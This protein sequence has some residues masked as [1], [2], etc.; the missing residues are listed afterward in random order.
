MIIK[1]IK[2]T[3]L[4]CYGN[5]GKD[6]AFNLPDGQNLGSGLNILVGKNN[7]GKSTLFEAIDFLRNGVSSTV[8]IS[9]L[10]NNRH[11][12]EEIEVEITFSEGI[13]EIVD[14]FSQE[15]K[16]ETFKKYIYKENETGKGQNMF[17][18]NYS[19]IP[20]LVEKANSVVRNIDPCNELAFVQITYGQ[21]NYLIAPDSDLFVFC[22]VD[23]QIK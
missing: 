18:S 5:S 17:N 1:S 3:N 6:I 14:N 9:E 19:D 23:K 15:N 22:A 4:K 10:K 11:P 16:K 20:K 2:I 21:N 7:S 13:T 8:N 12:N